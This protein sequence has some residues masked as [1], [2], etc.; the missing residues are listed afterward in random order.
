VRATP[1]DHADYP[2]VLQDAV[3]VGIKQ[4]VNIPVFSSARILAHSSAV[5]ELP[6][7]LSQVRWE[8][9]TVDRE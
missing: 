1:L 9:V 2:Q 7:Y 8:G 4:A 5:S 3:E 6:H